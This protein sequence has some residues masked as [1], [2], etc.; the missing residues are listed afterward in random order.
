M[1]FYHHPQTLLKHRIFVRRRGWLFFG[2]PLVAALTVI[3]LGFS[4]EVFARS[5][6]FAYAALTPRGVAPWMA[7]EG[8]YLSEYGIEAEL[9]YV[10]WIT[11]TQ[12]LIAGEIQLVHG[13]GVSASGAILAG[14]D[15]KIVASSLTRLRGFIC[16]RP[17]IKTP[18][19][20]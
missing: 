10:P 18:G 20:L 2:K 14:A 1:N 4:S 17:E 3:L 16:A 9:I 11:A 15:L 12:A 7:N 13:T 8:G 6:Q 5:I 19:Q